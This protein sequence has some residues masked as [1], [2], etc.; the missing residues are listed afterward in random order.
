[1]CGCDGLVLMFIYVMKLDAMI[2]D[3]VLLLIACVCDLYFV[4]LFIYVT[5]LV[6]NISVKH[7]Q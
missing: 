4:T 3:K 7:L 2:A 5:L 1:M 6:S